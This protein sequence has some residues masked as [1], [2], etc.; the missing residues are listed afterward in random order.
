MHKPIQF[1]GGDVDETIKITQVNRTGS[2]TVAGGVYVRDLL[3][4]ATESTSPTAGRGNIVAAATSNL[5]MPPVVALGPVADDA[6]GLFVV[7]GP[8]KAKVNGSVSIGDYLKTVNAKDYFE[9]CGFADGSTEVAWAI[10]LEA[11][12]SGEGTIEVLLLGT[13]YSRNPEDGS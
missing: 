7:K 4:S 12:T 5:A 9:A 1:P 8:C 3:Q 6:T 11:N 2:A 13:P 10:A